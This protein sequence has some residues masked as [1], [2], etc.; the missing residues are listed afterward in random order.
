MRDLIFKGKYRYREF[1]EAGEGISTNIL[2]DRL[3]KLER[4]GFILKEDDPHNGKQF[5][6]RPTE[7]G[8]DLIPVMLELIRWSGRYDS[9]TAAPKEFLSE[10]EASQKKLAEKI[11]KQFIK[12]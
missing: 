6:Y 10:V 12:S 9:K 2:A 3:D 4:D 1:L 8:L 11:K 7:K 5:I